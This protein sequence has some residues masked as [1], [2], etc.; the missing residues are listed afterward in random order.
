MSTGMGSRGGM[1]LGTNKD[2]KPN[3]GASTSTN[4]RSQRASGGANG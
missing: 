3:S 1:S 4:Q 2:S